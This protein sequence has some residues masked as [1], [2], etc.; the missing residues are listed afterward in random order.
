MKKIK[1]EAR[2]DLE[3]FGQ[4]V[5]RAFRDP[6][7]MPDRLTVI[8]LADEEQ[9]RLITPRRLELIRT[10]RDRGELTISELADEVGRWLDVVSRDLHALA[11]HSIIKL[12]REG[13]TKRVRLATELILLYV[14]APPEPVVA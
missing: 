7:G 9:D 6:E 5:Q 11:K 1:T 2:A 13:R 12:D 14:V 3:L 8:S 4:L 10:L